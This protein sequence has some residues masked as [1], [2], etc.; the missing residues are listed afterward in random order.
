MPNW[1]QIRNKTRY[2]PKV[3]KFH[4]E[5]GPEKWPKS[6]IGQNKM[7]RRDPMKLNFEVLNDPH[8]SFSFINFI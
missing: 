3:S 7:Q 6:C 4:A 1:Y 8:Y 2:T 5:K